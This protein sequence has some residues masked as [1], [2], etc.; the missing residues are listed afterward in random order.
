[1]EQKRGFRYIYTKEKFETYNKIP[2]W[3]KLEWLEKMNRFLYNFMPA[4]SK[5][6]REELKKV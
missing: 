2:T 5:E 4:K 1:M 3:Q 6:I